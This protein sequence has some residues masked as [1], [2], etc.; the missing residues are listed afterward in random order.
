MQRPAISFRL[1][2][3][4]EGTFDICPGNTQTEKIT[5]IIKSAFESGYPGSE[6]TDC[7]PTLEQ[8]ESL[9][10]QVNAL[11]KKAEYWDWAVLKHDKQLE[12]IEQK[13]S[14]RSAGV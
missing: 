13:L 7:S 10:Q 12:A 2:T 8:I 11:E 5:N 4:L 3:E 14:R 1:P 9:Q 6:I